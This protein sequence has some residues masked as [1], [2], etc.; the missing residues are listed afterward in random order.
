LRNW[1][2][3]CKDRRLERNIKAGQSP[4]SVVASDVEEEEEEEKEE[5]DQRQRSEKLGRD[6]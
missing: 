5:R 1:R 4:P 3:R 6:V 2:E